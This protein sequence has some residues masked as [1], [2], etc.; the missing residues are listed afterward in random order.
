VGGNRRSLLNRSHDVSL[1]KIS[2]G[3]TKRWKHEGTA[4]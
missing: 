3:A 1:E 2:P 4:L